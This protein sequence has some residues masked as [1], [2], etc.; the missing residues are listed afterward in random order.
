MAELDVDTESVRTFGRQTE[1]R[2]T[3]VSVEG[4]RGEFDTAVMASVFGLVG[5]D[6]MAMASL[7]TNNHNHQVTAIGERYSAV[8]RAVLGSANTY[9]TTDE[10]N[11]RQ[12]G[13]AGAS[14]AGA[15]TGLSTGID[16][17]SQNLTRE[18]VATIIID[19]GK[20]MGMTDDEITSAIATGLVES[21]LQNL[22]YGDRDSVGVFQQRNF[23]P[24]TTNGRNRLNVDEAATS[25][26][27][28]LRDTSGRP[29]DRAQMVQRSAYS[30]KYAERMSEASDLY[31]SLAT[32]TPVT[33][34][35]TRTAPTS[36]GVEVR[37]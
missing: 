3:T 5:A 36:P 14:S 30:M 33:A 16:P 18:Q 32:A 24:W 22:N 8:G 19:R 17:T 21:N 7:V 20:K 1:D 35:T 13:G 37:A 10:D 25:Y 2:G 29:G 4:H 12:F 28:Q 6:F 9:V 26:Y 34:T 23:E 31:T 11:G 27:E 15:L